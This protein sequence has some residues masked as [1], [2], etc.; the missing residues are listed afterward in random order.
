MVLMSTLGWAQ[1]PETEQEN[2]FKLNVDVDLVELH[3]TVLD[4]LERP[5][6]DPHGG[7]AA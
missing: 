5:V 4:E 1:S 7:P 6:H 2:T 3:V